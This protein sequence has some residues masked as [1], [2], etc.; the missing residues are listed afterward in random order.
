MGWNSISDLKSELYTNIPE[1]SYVYFVHSYYAET[2][3]L[4]ASQTEYIVPF[5]SSMKKN[6]FYA[7]QFHP[8]KSGDIGAQILKN[9]INL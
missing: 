9:F 8:E 4:S 5:A 6:N 3:E 2:N 1:K 7:V